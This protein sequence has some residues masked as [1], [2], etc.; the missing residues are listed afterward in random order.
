MAAEGTQCFN[1]FLRRISQ[2]STG[3]YTHI[4]IGFQIR[5]D[6]LD[7]EGSEEKIGKRV[8]SD[9]TNEI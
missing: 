5:D 2:N 8:G 1:V 9:T 3:Y 4:G 6:I 7:L